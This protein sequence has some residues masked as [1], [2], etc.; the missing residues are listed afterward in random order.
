MTQ[1]GFGWD[2]IGGWV[3]RTVGKIATFGSRDLEA[4][5]GIQAALGRGGEAIGGA[6]DVPARGVGAAIPEAVR[7]AGKG[8]VRAGTTAAEGVFQE[9]LAAPIRDFVDPA[10]ALLEGKNFEEY[11]EERQREIEQ[12]GR[13]ESAGVRALRALAAGRPVDLGEGFFPGGELQAQANQAAEA[14]TIKF[15]G[16]ESGVS[17]GRGLAILVS[18]PD[19]V[20][21]DVISGAVDLGVQLVDPYS[22]A[23]KAVSKARATGRVFTTV[24]EVD[25]ALAAERGAA[26]LLFGLRRGVVGTDTE[27]WLTTS[28]PGTAFVDWATANTDAYTIWTRLGKDRTPREVAVKLAEAETRDDVL[29]VMR[30]V[31][32]TGQVRTTTDL[33]PGGAVSRAVGGV[34]AG[35]EGRVFGA[36][37]GLIVKPRLDDVRLLHQMPGDDLNIHDL[38]DATRVLDDYLHNANI[39]QETRQ[40][41]VSDMLRVKE[42]NWEEVVDVRDRAQIAVAGKLAEKEV[43]ENLRS[44]L[45]KS[46]KEFETDVRVYGTDEAGDDLM[47]P[48]AKTVVIGG[49]EKALASAGLLVE[50]T[51]R[52][53]PLTSLD[54]VR[55]IRRLT[56]MAS[57]IYQSLPGKLLFGVH[58]YLL[59]PLTSA[60]WKPLVLLRLALPVRVL[61]EEQARM[62]T[63]GLDTLLNHPASYIAWLLGRKGEDSVE[64][65]AAAMSRRGAGYTGEAARQTSYAGTFREGVKEIWRSGGGRMFKDRVRVYKS[66]ADRDAYLDSWSGE[67]G[68][69]SS[70]PITRRVAGG[71]D[72]ADIRSLPEDMR[73]LQGFDAVHAWLLHGSGKELLDRLAAGGPRRQVLLQ[74][75]NTMGYLRDY[76][77]R[78]V[79]VMTKGNPDLIESIARGR[80]GDVAYGVDTPLHEL[81]GVLGRYY[82]EFGPDVVPGDRTRI[83]GAVEKARDL[84][85]KAVDTLFHAAMSFPTNKFSRGSAVRQFHA[86]R[87]ME[88]AEW[89]DEAAQREIIEWLAEHGLKGQAKRLTDLKAA[90]KLKARGSLTSF[91]QAD[92]V[93]KAWAMKQTKDLLYDVSKKGQAADAMRVIFPFLEPWKEMLTVWTK[94]TKD[95]Y[96]LPIRRA[97]QV[98]TSGERTGMFTRDEDD[99]ELKFTY[100]LVGKMTAELLGLPD[101]TDIAF[102]G[103]VS[104]LN[105]AS[106]VWPG[107]GPVAQVAASKIWDWAPSLRA[108]NELVFPMGELHVEDAD[109]VLDAFLPAYLKKAKEVLFWDGRPSE[110]LMDFAGQHWMETARVLHASGEYDLTTEEGVA[111][112]QQDVDRIAR[113]SLG[114]R[115]LAQFGLPTGPEFE[116][117]VEDKDGRYLTTQAYGNWMRERYEA[118]GGRENP[119]AWFRAYEDFVTTF[120]YEPHFMAQGRSVAVK[121]R[122]ETEEGRRW[123]QAIPELRDALPDVLGFFAPGEDDGSAER[124]AWDQLIADGV[125]VPLTRE[126][127]VQAAM[128]RRDWGIYRAAQQKTEGLDRAEKATY[129]REVREAIWEENRKWQAGLGAPRSVGR[130]VMEGQLR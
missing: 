28:K 22:K 117:R 98:I 27:K 127:V 88:L 32:G 18:D 38:D 30:G 87:L 64:D 107:V 126:Q 125:R 45:T 31:I 91:D 79:Q 110:T 19:T 89:G 11:Q 34:L 71:L 69:L 15:Q 86:Q 48:G 121:E 123:E 9:A 44:Q 17:L 26:G 24:D 59:A 46:V 104:G 62:T 108:F 75:E 33:V 73:D 41:L 25:D 56:G 35:Q 99:G 82:D 106:Q 43:P 54:D 130:G 80:I 94:L 14:R 29:D 76:V 81:R 115:S 90:G 66:L 40:S 5:Q 100:P 58:D 65:F 101:G 95:T 50:Y 3:G 16:R 83:L 8:A 7:R 102:K 70:D 36:G 116:F 23:A 4:A 118:H 72:E 109:D 128:D 122:A 2:D 52:T 12:F 111:R 74:P 39:S 13:D 97:Q 124:A 51:D 1:D 92:H 113:R 78:R 93:A 77:D 120:G 21:F 119:G 114:V 20:A 63:A 55:E 105:L 129:L 49:E 47:F 112:F 67:L 84:R 68:K 85:R 37:R 10:F 57:G 96:G 103:R 61:M 53:V 42:G 60:I 6:V